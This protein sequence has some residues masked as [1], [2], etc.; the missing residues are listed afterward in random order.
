[1]KQ[2]SPTIKWEILVIV[3]GVLIA[4]VAIYF[5]ASSQTGEIFYSDYPYE[6]PI[7]GSVEVILPSGDS[8]SYFGGPLSCV[9]PS[10]DTVLFV[11]EKNTGEISLPSDDYT[12]SPPA[13]PIT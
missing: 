1:M 7:D 5:V 3:I 10:G 11:A 13:T 8:F 4:F 9:S 12:C 6:D 2:A